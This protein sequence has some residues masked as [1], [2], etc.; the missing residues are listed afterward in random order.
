MGLVTVRVPEPCR[1]GP[2]CHAEVGRLGRLSIEYLT[3]ERASK[4]KAKLSVPTRRELRSWGAGGWSTRTKLMDR[5]VLSPSSSKAKAKLN[6][7]SWP[8]LV[9][10]TD[11]GALVVSIINTAS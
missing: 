2:R 6:Q 8:Q 1:R 4:S 5:L 3:P 9:R 7:M 11:H 10:V